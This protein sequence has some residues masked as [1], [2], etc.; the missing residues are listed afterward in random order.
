MSFIARVGL[1]RSALVAAAVLVLAAVGPVVAAATGPSVPTLT[2]PAGQGFVVGGQIGTSDITVGEPGYDAYTDGIPMHLTWSATGSSDMFFDVAPAETAA[3]SAADFSTTIDADTY[4][5]WYDVKMSDYD[6]GL[7]CAY[8]NPVTGY[9]VIA[10]DP[11]GALIGKRVLDRNPTVYQEDGRVPDTK[12][13]APLTV[14]YSGTWTVGSCTCASGG[15]QKGSRSAGAAVTI[16]RT[17]EAGSH[18]ALVMAEG[19]GRGKATVTIDG[20]KVGTVDTYAAGSNRNRIIVFDHAMTTGKHTVRLVNSGTAGH[21]RVD[22]DAIL[23][24]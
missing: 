10:T 14:G 1:G 7:P 20:T 12:V 3:C 18:L 15:T 22:L 8:G 2:A 16:T 19:P 21:P 6:G 17:F 5:R 11:E 9:T 4:N 23:V 24:S 13:A